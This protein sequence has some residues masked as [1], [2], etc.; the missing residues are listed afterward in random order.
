MK[1]EHL[2][3]RTASE[4]ALIRERW[5]ES[6]GLSWN[7]DQRFSRKNA[8]ESSRAET[9]SSQNSLGALSRA[10]PKGARNHSREAAVFWMIGD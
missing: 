2:A 8:T 9:E 3:W 7:T 5:M 10:H 1:R 6:P 4:V